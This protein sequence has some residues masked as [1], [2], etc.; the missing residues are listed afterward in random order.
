MHIFWL[1]FILKLISKIYSFLKG[2]HL[3]CTFEGML[4]LYTLL[5]RLNIIFIYIAIEKCTQTHIWNHPS[6]TISSPRLISSRW[7]N[8]WVVSYIVAYVDY[9]LWF[10]DKFNII[11]TVVEGCDKYI[12]LGGLRLFNVL[13]V[14]EVT[15][16]YNE[17]NIFRYWMQIYEF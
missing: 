7:S 6:L 4:L 9:Y 3:K 17:T 2:F 10:V 1:S 11:I 5:I 15:I 8:F 16:C 14:I 12:E 13:W